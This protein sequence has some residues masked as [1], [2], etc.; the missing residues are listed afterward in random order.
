M[1]VRDVATRQN[2]MYPG[3]LLPGTCQDFTYKAELE[4]AGS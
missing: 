2:G 1:D 3:G 4:Q